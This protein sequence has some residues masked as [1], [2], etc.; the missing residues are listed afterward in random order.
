MAAQMTDDEEYYV[1][2]AQ[3]GQNTTGHHKYYPMV[4]PYK[5]IRFYADPHDYLLCPPV[6]NTRIDTD[7]TD[8]IQGKYLALP[9]EDKHVYVPPLFFINKTND[10]DFIKEYTGLYFITV[11]STPKIKSIQKLANY[12]DWCR[13]IGADAQFSYATLFKTINTVLIRT[14]G[15]LPSNVNVGIWSCQTMEWYADKSVVPTMEK[16]AIATVAPKIKTSAK[17]SDPYNEDLRVSILAISIPPERL[18]NP[19]WIPLG[20]QVVQG[21]GLNVLSYFGIIPEE[22]ARSR[23]ATLCSKGQSIFNICAY[24]T[25]YFEERGI[26]DTDML[27]IRLDLHN[28][29][30]FLH[31]HSMPGSVTFVKMYDHY[32]HKEDKPS[33]VGHTVALFKTAQGE[34]QLVDPQAGIIFRPIT[35]E[36]LAQTYRP[37]QFMD[38]ILVVRKNFP[39]NRWSMNYDEFVRM[40]HDHIIQID[41]SIKYGGKRTIR[42]RTI[43][44]RKKRSYRK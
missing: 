2:A 38:I 5:S 20:R 39:E 26:E 12:Y 24:L 8:I 40:T 14:V 22:E 10:T 33:H 9:D 17:R 25:T 34:L 42:K 29:Y 16:N 31:D 37:K 19:S 4:I 11:D 30:R 27:I 1:I 6:L 23:V 35:V 32:Y 36:Q 7:A 21:C 18:A 28:G 44:K 15:H 3:H 41:G 43:R 13:M